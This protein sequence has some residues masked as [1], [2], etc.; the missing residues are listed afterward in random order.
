M[1]S[2]SKK[3]TFEILFAATS[4]ENQEKEEKSTNHLDNL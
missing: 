3:D 2:A 1:C 4:D